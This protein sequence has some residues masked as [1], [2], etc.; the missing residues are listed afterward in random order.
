MKIDTLSLLVPLN[1]D[2]LLEAASGRTAVSWLK[3]HE[4]Q[5]VLTGIN[6]EAVLHLHGSYREPESVILGLSSYL[7]VKDHPHAKT[8]LQLF[9]M[10]RTLFFVGCGDTVID[11]NFT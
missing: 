1:Y 7:A 5:E 6:P 10:D 3:S 2:H 8:V 4:T 9:T 11:P